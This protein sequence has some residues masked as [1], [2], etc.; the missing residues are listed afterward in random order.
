MNARA[1]WVK[2]PGV[3]EGDDEERRLNGEE[4]VS[5][6]RARIF[7]YPKTCN[8]LSPRLSCLEIF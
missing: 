5:R 2:C 3:N 8:I 4:Y 6:L 1:P 7:S